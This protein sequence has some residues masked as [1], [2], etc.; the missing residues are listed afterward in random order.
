MALAARCNVD[1]AVAVE[2]E[3]LRAP[4]PGKKSRHLAG[5]VDLQNGIETRHRGPRGV[6]VAIGP[7]AKVKCGYAG[8][9]SSERSRFA[10]LVQDI[11]RA[12]SIAKLLLPSVAKVQTVT[13]PHV[14]PKYFPF[15]EGVN[16][17]PRAVVAAGNK[18]FA[19]RAKA[20]A[21]GLTR[22]VKKG[23]LSPSEVI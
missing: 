16:P 4:E 12:V 2:G 22:S 13:N 14:P 3:T 23:S 9:E 10:D 8:F 1:V 19:V 5:A 15:F 7:E 6:Q 18:L 20:M 11:D 21:V 17:A